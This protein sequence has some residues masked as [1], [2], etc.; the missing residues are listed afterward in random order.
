MAAVYN[1]ASEPLHLHIYIQL[2]VL[3][4]L[5]RLVLQVIECIYISYY[6]C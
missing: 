4:P 5:L 6:I 3:N 2:P 1:L